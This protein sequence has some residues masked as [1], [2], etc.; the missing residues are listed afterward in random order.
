MEGGF[1]T[2]KARKETRDCGSDLQIAIDGL[3]RSKDSRGEIEAYVSSHPK[4]RMAKPTRVSQFP[5]MLFCF[6]DTFSIISRINF[7]TS[8]QVKIADGMLTH[9]P[10]DNKID[11][12]ILF[13]GVLYSINFNFVVPIYSQRC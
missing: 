11:C 9:N 4:G 10:S 6:L 7:A 1:I 3:F 12:L 8:F 13:Q 2:K 5:N